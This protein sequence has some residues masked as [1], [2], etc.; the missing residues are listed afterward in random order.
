MIRKSSDVKGIKRNGTEFKL[1]QY[2]HDTQM[3]LDGSEASMRSA[4]I[5]LQQFYLMS[6]LK[7]NLDQTKALWIGSMC[8]SSKIICREFNIDWEQ[9]H[10]KY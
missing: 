4:L 5:I 7:I 10:L 1:S 3:F 9:K 6:G 2:A 8:R